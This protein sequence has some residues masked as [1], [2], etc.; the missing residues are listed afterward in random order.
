LIGREK[1][2]VFLWGGGDFRGGGA[3]KG[4]GPVTGFSRGD[5]FFFRVPKPVMRPVVLW[6]GVSARSLLGKGPGKGGGIPHFWVSTGK[7]LPWRPG[8]A[9][10]FS[11][12]F[13][14]PRGVWA[15]LDGGRK[16]RGKGG[17]GLFVGFFFGRGREPRGGGGGEKKQLKY[18]GG[19]RVGGVGGGGGGVGRWGWETR[20]GGN[21]GA[22][23]AG[24][25]NKQSR[26]APPGGSERRAGRPVKKKKNRIFLKRFCDGGRKTRWGGGRNGRDRFAGRKKVSRGV[27]GGGQT[28]PLGGFLVRGGAP[29]DPGTN[30]FLKG[31]GGGGGR[32]G[33]PGSSFG[34]RGGPP[35]G[36]SGR[37]PRKKNKTKRPAGPG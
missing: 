30:L 35:R 5:G 20:E 16:K 11:T 27:G 3:R 23:P 2:P 12:V 28:S 9:L 14:P 1:N 21:V 37:G 10:G 36:V 34:Q 17:G 4:S 19:W 33:T 18:R 8:W 13:G 31:A 22:N 25:K 7:K 29:G 6:S 32:P 26:G 24:D 15:F